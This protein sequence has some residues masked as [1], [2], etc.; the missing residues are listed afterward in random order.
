[1]VVNFFDDDSDEPLFDLPA[2]AP[3]GPKCYVCKRR[4]VIRSGFEMDSDKAGTLEKGVIIAAL[5]ER[6][7]DSGT[8]RIRFAGGWAS[9]ATSTGAPVSAATICPAT[10]L[11]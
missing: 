5:E 10:R 1:M 3:A 7:N 9:K 2:P 4:S 8:V 6:V 11:V